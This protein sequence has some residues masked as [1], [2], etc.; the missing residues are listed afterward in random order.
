MYCVIL[1]YYIS[2]YTI[3]RLHGILFYYSIYYYTDKQHYSGVCCLHPFYLADFAVIT[4]K[5]FY[6]PVVPCKATL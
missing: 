6:I 2:P 4:Q 1:C 3:L 5:M